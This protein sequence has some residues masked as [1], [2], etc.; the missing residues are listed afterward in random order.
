MSALKIGRQ[1]RPSR[2]AINA[3]ALN[4]GRL[5]ECVSPGVEPVGVDRCGLAPSALRNPHGARGGLGG[6]VA[7]RDIARRDGDVADEW[8]V[9]DMVPASRSDVVY[10]RARAIIT[11][12][13]SPDVSFDRAIDP[14]R[15]REHGGAYG[16]MR[17]VHAIAGAG[18]D[19][20]GGERLFA[21]AGAADL[22]ENELASPRYRARAI[23]LGTDVDPYHPVE[24]TERV[25]R[26]ILEVLAKA[27]HPIGIVTKS[28]LVLRDLDLLAPMARK[29]LVKVA[30]AIP[31]LDPDLARR[32]EPK[33]SAPE[34]RLHAIEELSKAGV[35]VTAMIAPIIPAL[36]DAEIETILTRAYARGAREAGYVMLRLPPELQDL[37][38]AWL[39]AHY[40]DKHRHVT[41]LVKSASRG[42]AA[43]PGSRGAKVEEAGGRDDAG[44]DGIPGPLAWTIGRRFETALA[45]N[46]YA[47]RGVS[48]RTDLFT[49]PIATGEQLS[50]LL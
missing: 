47:S 18:P 40:P 15:A 3:T 38:G 6:V 10:E 41:T 46:G 7:R 45:K 44:A 17:Q 27:N 33:T 23:A 2:D 29:G 50:L 21:K 39:L 9:L 4:L 1:A 11:R 20:D 8:S 42:R 12:N 35:P 14:Y 31:T 36:N 48:V 24:R 49:R 32:L 34:R 30:V 13:T 25:T 26:G 5:A 19:V 22:L 28:A 16:F 37:F 43:D